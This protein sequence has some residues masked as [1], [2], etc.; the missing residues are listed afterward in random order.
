MALTQVIKIGQVALDIFD[1]SY[2]LAVERLIAPP[3]RKGVDIEVLTI[4]VNPLVIDHL[5][6]VIGQPLPRLRVS[7]VQELPAPVEDSI[8]RIGNSKE[9]FRVLLI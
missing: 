4:N 6:D 7:Q 8:I 3:E 5:I 9:P 1:L 2:A